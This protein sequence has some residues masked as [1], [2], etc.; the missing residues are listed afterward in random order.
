[1]DNIRI[2][3]N[4]YLNKYTT[5]RIGGSAEWL[6]EPK[7][8]NELNFLLSW[9]EKKNISCNIIGAGSN[10]L[11]ND[12]KIKGLSLCMRKLNGCDLNPITGE[13]EVLC[14]ESLP[15][16]ARKAA[17]AG[18]HGLEWAIGIPG[19]IGGA[20]V[21]NAGAQGS[22]IAE[23][24]KG[25]R[26]IPKKGGEPFDMKPKDLDFS[27]R[28]SRLQ[29]E[30]LIA[31]SG[32]FQLD[33]GHNQEKINRITKLNLNKRTKT[34]PYHQPSCGSVFRNPE[35]LKAGQLIEN[36]GLKGIR[37]GGAE[38]SKIHA[39]FIIN[40]SN[41]KASDF[42]NLITFIQEKIYQAYGVLLDTEVKELGF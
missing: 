23:R 9:A 38:V 18:L 4:I 29:H 13:I 5:L 37:I 19:T 6:S 24:I 3:E 12:N 34:Q 17:N 2:E 42:K 20:I 41:A 33:P 14:G 26:V 21:M 35:P 27:Y 1:M 16:L 31:L 28:D 32:R 7:N 10:L 8:I 25:I 39:N 15:N 22:C 36:L 40:R 11:I 30:E